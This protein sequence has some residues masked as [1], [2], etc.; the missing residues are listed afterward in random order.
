MLAHAAL[1]KNLTLLQQWDTVVI[2]DS[3]IKD[4]TSPARP[5]MRSK[6][7]ELVAYSNLLSK[8]EAKLDQ[9]TMPARTQFEVQ[10]LFGGSAGSTD[11]ARPGQ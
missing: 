7:E 4:A 1:P 5:P 2:G 10:T 6:Q 3:D 9:L 11:A 8:M